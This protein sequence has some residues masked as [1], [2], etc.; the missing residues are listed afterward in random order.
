VRT[1]TN[2][3]HT[4]PPD[5]GVPGTG[6]DARCLGEDVV[7]AVGDV[8]EFLDGF[9]EVATFGGVSHG[10]AVQSAIKKRSLLVIPQR[11]EQ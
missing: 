6:C 5:A 8:A 4:V 3:S 10:C 11:I 7:S 2:S 9:V 1:G